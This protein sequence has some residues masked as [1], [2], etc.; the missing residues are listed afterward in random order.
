MCSALSAQVLSASESYKDPSKTGIS[1]MP[2]TYHSY[3]IA[4]KDTSGCRKMVSVQSGTE[5][6]SYST[7]WFPSDKTAHCF[8][9]LNG[10][11]EQGLDRLYCLSSDVSKCICP[12]KDKWSWNKKGRLFLDQWIL[13]IVQYMLQYVC[14][15]ALLC[16]LCVNRSDVLCVLWVCVCW[17]DSSTMMAYESWHRSKPFKFKC[18]IFLGSSVAGGMCERRCRLQPMVCILMWRRVCVYVHPYP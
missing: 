4:G 15:T 7:C 9:S 18:Y 13:L 14:V 12:C 10:T 2:N 16:L 1:S 17:K 8:T 5:I 11:Y 6:S 3:E